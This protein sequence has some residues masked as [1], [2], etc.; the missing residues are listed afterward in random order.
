MI[1]LN[2]RINLDRA[3]AAVENAST[4]EEKMRN[5]SKKTPWFLRFAPSRLQKKAII[6]IIAVVALLTP[7]SAMA[8]HP[9]IVFIIGWTAGQ[10]LTAAKQATIDKW[11]AVK[12]ATASVNGAYWTSNSYSYELTGSADYSPPSYRS[13]EASQGH[14]IHDTARGTR[15]GVA[16][17][18]STASDYLDEQGRYTLISAH[19]WAVNDDDETILVMW[20]IARE[21]A[22]PRLK[23]RTLYTLR[24]LHDD[25]S[26]QWDDDLWIIHK[27]KRHVGSHKMIS[28]YNDP[29]VPKVPELATPGPD[30]TAYYTGTVRWDRY[31]VRRNGR[32]S[33]KRVRNMEID[34]FESYREECAKTEQLCGANQVISGQHISAS[35]ARKVQENS[36]RI[37]RP[38]GRW[39]TILWGQV[40]TNW[41]SIVHVNNGDL[42]G[43]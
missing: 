42:Y 41:L 25:R 22:F 33:P 29:N 1:Q 32:L 27:V 30:E 39:R 4:G 37:N 17:D 11:L 38:G 8:L 23:H 24:K 19:G 18:D 6:A 34:D 13:I 10:V 40:T 26:Y 5:S 35:I 28:G 16:M 15:D 9:A 31:L 2:N 43:D 21:D 12:K 20:M 7:V 14:E 36:M 3:V